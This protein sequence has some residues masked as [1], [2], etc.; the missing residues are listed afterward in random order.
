MV[1]DLITEERYANLTRNMRWKPII[2]K[3]REENNLE[4]DIFM[5]EDEFSRLDNVFE[6]RD[7]THKYLRNLAMHGV[8]S[9][10]L[11]FKHEI[12]RK[13]FFRSRDSLTELNILTN[14]RNPSLSSLGKAY[15][16]E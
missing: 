14:Q 6:V 2:S 13:M 3:Y 12:D 5:A 9:A 10:T 4:S 15:V 1:E 7:Y 11:F 16:L 8:M